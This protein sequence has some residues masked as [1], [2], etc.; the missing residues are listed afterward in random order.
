VFVQTD[1]EMRIGFD[2][3]RAFLNKAGLGNYSRNTLVALHKYYPQHH[4]L[5]FTPEYRTD[6]FKEYLFFDTVSPANRLLPIINSLWRSFYLSEKIKKSGLDL[7]HGLS[8]ELPSWIHK[9]GVRSVVTIHDLI[10]MNFPGLYKAIDRKIYY[11]KVKYA[12]EFADR[13]ITT[14]RQTCSDLIHH[15]RVDP[16]KV[17]VI[18]QSISERFFLK[19]YMDDLEEVRKRYNLPGNFILTVGT[20]EPRKNQ[21]GVLKALHRQ[22]ID[23]PYVIVGRSTPY[24]DQILEYVKKYQLQNR[25]YILHDVP[26]FDL[27]ALY[28]LAMCMVYLSHYEGFGLPLVEAMACRCPV[29][30]SSV[31]SL[32]EIGNHAALYCNPEDEETVAKSIL[33]L[34]NNPDFSKEMS[35]KGEKRAQLFHPEGRINDLMTF[36]KKVVVHG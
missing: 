10:F 4:Y 8:N 21:L 7:F 15:L 28:H 32:P 11:E 5:L 16:E 19:Y 14:S 13:I 20:I 34:I 23:I 25:V 9:S 30:T 29:I 18:Y 3:K 12:C 36:Y 6:I 1:Q 31:S 22:K 2:A 26:D 27:P 33:K 35:T 24:K 17:E